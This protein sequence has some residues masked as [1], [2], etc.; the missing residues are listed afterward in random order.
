MYIG[1]IAKHI[2]AEQSHIFSIKVT[3]I[4]ANSLKERQNITYL[5]AFAIIMVVLYHAVCDILCAS[6]PEDMFAAG[7]KTVMENVH[8]PLFFLI[9]GYLCH[10]QNVKIF[11][12][13]KIQRILIPFLFMSCLKLI[14]NNFISSAHI[15]GEGIGYQLFDA[16]VCGKLYWFCYALLIMYA[17]APL[18]W[19]RKLCIWIFMVGSLAANIILS[20]Y[21]MELTYVLQIENAVY[22]LPFFMTGMLLAQYNVL[23]NPVSITL[24][25]L[26]SLAAIMT[27][28]VMIYIELALGVDSYSINFFMGLSIMYIL[29][30]IAVSLNG[31]VADK[32]FTLPSR[33]S[34]QI[35]LLDSFYRILLISVIS[36][37]MNYDL[38]MVIIV[39]AMVLLLSCATCRLL[40]KIPVIRVFLGL[41]NSIS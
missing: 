34:F 11:Y 22:Q 33:Y 28:V 36:K 8:V 35:M 2:S 20:I 30:N 7:I 5:K 25:I 6:N 4:M 9:A 32:I 16:F 1:G 18:L 38:W 10:K 13:K 39:S 31:T 17:A 24:R 41:K 19:N 37:F 15:H 12:K 29:Y 14:F 27:A 26:S 23:R 3:A 21:N 40:V